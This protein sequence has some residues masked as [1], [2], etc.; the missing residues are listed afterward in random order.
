MTYSELTLY[1]KGFHL[2]LAAHNGGRDDT[3]WKLMPR[4]WAAYLHDAVESGKMV[5]D[6]ANDMQEAVKEM[7]PPEPISFNVPRPPVKP[8]ETVSPVA[9]FENDIR[10]LSALLSQD[11]P[12]KKLVQ[13]SRVYTILYEG[14]C[15]CIGIWI[16]QH[17]SGK[18][19]H[20]IQNWDL[21]CRHPRIIIK[22][23]RV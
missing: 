17:C 14:V 15:R 23:S 10:A 13:A 18:R 6:E 11:E 8:P 12:A 21:G 20:Q 9:Q 3:G 22:H 16:Q 1:L 5:Q 4:E 19:W 2:T 7:A